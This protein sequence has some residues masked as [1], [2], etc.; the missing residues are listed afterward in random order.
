[1][2]WL[3]FCYNFHMNNNLF[4]SVTKKRKICNTKIAKK[5]VYHGLLYHVNVKIAIENFVQKKKGHFYLASSVTL[6]SLITVT[7]IVPG[8]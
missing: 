7:L 3:T 5:V 2:V 6:V 8:Y 4:D 1:M